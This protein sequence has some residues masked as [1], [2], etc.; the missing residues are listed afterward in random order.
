MAT[1]TQET[2]FDLARHDLLTLS[3]ARDHVLDCL[4]GEVW[5][6]VDRERRDIVLAPGASYRIES[7]APVVISAL[8][9]ATLTMRHRQAFGA[10]MTG[11]RR[12]LVSLMNWEFPPLAAFPSTLIR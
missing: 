10:R 1:I 8:Q 5:I 2:R 11:A 6:T 4:S 3:D 9:A 12:L 7:R